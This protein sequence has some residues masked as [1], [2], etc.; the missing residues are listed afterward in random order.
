MVLGWF[1]KGSPDLATEE[2]R[3]LLQTI[4]QAMPDADEE[5]VRIVAAC[6]GL[7]ASVA[8]ADRNF[9]QHEAERIEQLLQTIQ[10]I[11][12]SGTQAIVVALQKDAL[13]YSTVQTPRFTRTLKELAD[14]DLRLHVLQLLVD[15]A[16][17]DEEIRHDEVT[18]LRQLTAALGLEQAD[19]NAAQ[20]QH[21]AKLSSL[22]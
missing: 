14:R 1:R 22:R 16:A 18:M 3:T 4:G 19:Y 6:A 20:E 2:D 8:Y 15:V 17:A 21:K 13:H 11:G 5:S 10:G 12:N 7:L 9:S